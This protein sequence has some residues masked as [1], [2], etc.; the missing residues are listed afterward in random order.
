MT[1][2]KETLQEAVISAIESIDAERQVDGYATEYLN[3]AT[4][5][6]EWEREVIADAA[7]ATVFERLRTPSDNVIWAGIEARDKCEQA[8]RDREKSDNPENMPDYDEGDVAKFMLQAMLTAF[9]Q[10]NK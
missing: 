10:E 6:S 1:Q 7:T 9:Q 5:L 2:D 3:G 4:D 8:M